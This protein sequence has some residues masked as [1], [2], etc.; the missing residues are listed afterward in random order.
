MRAS[1]GLISRSDSVLM[2]VDFQEKLVSAMSDLAEVSTNINALVQSAIQLGVPLTVTEHC[3]HKIG[4]TVA[5]VRGQCGSEEILTKTTFDAL[6]EQ[7]IARHMETLGRTQIVVVGTESHVCVLQ[8]IFGL[9]RHGYEPYVVC[10][11]VTSRKVYDKEKALS[12]IA[13]HSV[14]CVTTEMVL[15]EWLARGDTP[16]FKKLIPLIKDLKRES[17][18]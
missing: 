14:Q 12:R 16:E 17:R 9:L 1:S 7:S 4:L 3:P 5:S 15:F 11:A 2:I 6:S 18:K 13:A 8:T 10:D